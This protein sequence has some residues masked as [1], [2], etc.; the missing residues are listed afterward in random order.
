MADLTL[1]QMLALLPDNTT[2][3][4]SPQD[5]RD[6]VTALREALEGTNPLPALQFDTTPDAAAH[7]TGR[8]YWN[9]E[10]G[11]IEIDTT[12]SGA[13]LEVGYEQWLRARNTTGSTIPDGSPVRVTGASGNRPLISI[14]NGTGTSIGLTT[15]D[16]ANNA[17]GRVT[18]FGLVHGLNTN[19]FAAG[20]SLYV[21]SAGALSTTPSPTFLGT[22]VNAHLTQGIIFVHPQSFDHPDGTTAARP[23]TV[24]TGYMYFDTTLGKPIWWSGAAWV[25][26]TGSV[27]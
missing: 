26:A 22:V 18:T 27:V 4:I 10:N 9:A 23:T 19:A 2:G 20:N 24:S 7:S 13:S 8:I 21:T 16:I 15:E 14:G 3:Q 25:D 12:T 17:N 5:M 11:S 1:T 6:I